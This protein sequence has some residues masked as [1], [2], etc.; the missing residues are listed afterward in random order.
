MF[1]L[2][3][4]HLGCPGQNPESHEMVVCVFF[5]HLYQKI[6]FGDKWQGFYRTDTLLDTQP[7]VLK[8]LKKYTILTQPIACPRPYFI[9]YQIPD[10]EKD[11]SLNAS[12]L[13]PARGL[14][15]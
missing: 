11:C 4:A 10:E 7:S 12:S 2:V 9:H 3:S 8:V 6:I 1:L 14:S 13:S 15:V 5:L